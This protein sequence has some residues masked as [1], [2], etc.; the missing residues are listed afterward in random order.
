[1]QAIKQLIEK[2]NY[3]SPDKVTLVQDAYDFSARAHE[4]Q[5]SFSG[6]SYIEHPLQVALTLAQLR[7]DA[8]SLAAALLHDV[9]EKC[10]V[11]I[12][13]IEGHFGSEV[14]KLVNRVTRLGKISWAG[15]DIARRESQARNQRKMLVAMAEDIRVVFIALADRLHNM[16][17]L[18]AMP[19]E[20]QRSIAHETMEV[21][22]PLAHRLGIRE[23]QWQLEDLSFRYIEPDKYRQIAQLIGVR[24][25]QRESFITQAIQILKKDFEKVGLKA[26]MSGY[27]KSNF[28][29]YQKM[30]KYEKIGKDFSDIHNL[31][32]VQVLLATITDCYQALGLINKLWPP[33]PN[34]F[35]DYIANPK[36]NGYKSLHTTVMCMGSTPLE[37]Q[38]RTYEMHHAAEYGLAA[39]W[40]YKEGDKGDNRF[41]ERVSWLRQLIDSRWGSSGAEECLES[42]KT[43]ILNDRVFVYTPRGEIKDLPRGS[44]PIDLAY[45][46]STDLGHNCVGSKVNGKLVSLNYQLNNGDVVEIMTVEGGKGPSRDWLRPELGYIRT[47]SAREKIRKWFKMQKV[48]DKRAVDHYENGNRFIKQG[49]IEKALS[50]LKHAID[51]APDFAEAH[52]SLGLCFYQLTRWQEAL[53]EYRIALKIAPDRAYIHSN[54]GHALYRLGRL[55]EAF[56]E[57]N[58]AVKMEP[59]NAE[60]HY[61]LG[62]C[63]ETQHNV[64]NAIREYIE[65]I[66]IR[67][68]MAEAH[69]N[70][71]NM[72]ARQGAIEK[73]AI[74]YKEALGINRKDA[75]AYIGLGTIQGVFKEYEEA[76]KSYRS[77]IKFAGSNYA[78]HIEQAKAAISRFEDE[79]QKIRKIPDVETLIHRGELLLAEHRFE[80]AAREFEKVLKIKPDLA[81]AHDRL[82]NAW[83]HQGKH[84][85][86]IQAYREAIRLDP[87]FAEAITDL[88][89]VYYAQGRIDDALAEYRK[90]IKA[91]P[92]YAQAH[93]DLGVL[94][95]DQGKMD[96]AIEEYHISLKLAPRSAQTH[97]NLAHALGSIGKLDESI[98]EC[99]EAL[100]LDPQYANAHLNL[101]N[102]LYMKEEYE[103]AV[104]E[105]REV[106][107]IEPES[108]KAR[109]N[110]GNTLALMGRLTEAI[111]EFKAAQAIK[112][113]NADIYFN[114]GIA[115][116]NLRKYEDAKIMIKQALSISPNLVGWGGKLGSTFTSSRSMEEAITE[117]REKGETDPIRKMAIDKAVVNYRFAALVR[118][119][120][121]LDALLMP[122][123]VFNVRQHYQEM[124]RYMES[125]AGQRSYSRYHYLCNQIARELVGTGGDVEDMANWVSHHCKHVLHYLLLSILAK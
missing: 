34:E 62:R 121:R 73:A 27:T 55:D 44:T 90:A 36:P 67:P 113:D 10:R 89:N 8:A 31:L 35:D 50:E 77:F 58:E 102:A 105:Y 66:R 85:K 107:R 118:E 52:Y 78:S 20:K 16:Q 54:M 75:L 6:A 109:I 42:V 110:L 95:S 59:E 86:A 124:R 37:L 92:D 45:L 112:P 2:A 1:M 32:T 93:S 29:I 40:R 28:S 25:V 9:P 23:L 15:E 100:R 19:P 97:N 119:C 71:A 60:F 68:K 41:E 3:L 72:Y 94:L 49:D 82:G 26:E 38:I 106:I 14:A 99:R 61:N 83:Y 111:S 84:D 117:Y 81:L 11:P 56:K 53:E 7:L 43:D 65:A 79:M 46:V 21:Y 108:V 69:T 57:Y 114:M 39:H 104:Q 4:G 96:E 88:G 115:F 120:A 48:M 74:E 24:R 122:S 91:D 103:S 22:A 51:I 5:L 98:A 63:Y 33:L 47:S 13:D 17:T 125:P 30:Q 18:D 64:E 87:G 80:E 12:I 123:G 116:C 101:G 76:I 70:L